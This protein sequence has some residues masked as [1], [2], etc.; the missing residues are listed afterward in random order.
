MPM[1]TP[2]ERKRGG[3]VP[4]AVAVAIAL[5]GTAAM[6]L[7]EFRPNSDHAH[8]GVSMISAAAADRAGATARPT[9]PTRVVR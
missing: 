4:I 6:F 3:F 9:T 5:A 1:S 8:H 7:I 2:V